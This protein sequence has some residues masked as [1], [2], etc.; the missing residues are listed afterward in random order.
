M[1]FLLNAFRGFLI[2]VAEVIPGVSGGT[3]ALVV[4]VYERVLDQAAV[5][6]RSFAGITK[7]RG[8]S[9]ASLGRLDFGFLLPLLVGMVSAILLA[10]AILEPLLIREPE[11]TLAL[12]AGLIAVS[13]VVPLR[14]VS[15]WSAKLFAV[16][17]A[18][19]VAAF[20]LTSLPRGSQ[21]NPESWFVFLAAAIAVCA[22]VLPGVSGSFFLLAIGLYQPTIAAVNELD[23]AYLG[24]FALGALVGFF[25]FALLMQF[26][27]SKYRNLTLALM[28][29]L[30]LGSLR[31]LWPWQSSSAEILSPS[32]PL[33]PALACLAGGVTVAALIVWQGRLDRRARQ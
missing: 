12:F 11:I 2:G 19:A 17:G 7:T 14:M 25:S 32:D 8:K 6:S 3:V 4:G 18:G 23:F 31:A 30:M 28:A 15:A 26:L 9:L 10:A 24:F 21:A 1:T 20:W 22:L 27:L 5:I 33:G 29:G 16:G 13:V